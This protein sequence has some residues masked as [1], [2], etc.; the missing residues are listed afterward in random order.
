M[1]VQFSN[2]ISVVGGLTVLNQQVP[3]N[4]VIAKTFNGVTTWDNTNSYSLT[5]M[6]NGAAAPTI[7]SGNATTSSANVG[8]YTSFLT[9]SLNLS[10]IAYT[11]TD[12]NVSATISQ[13]P[14]LYTA[15]GS[16]YQY[17]TADPLSVNNGSL[18]GLFSP[19][20]RTNSTTGT[21]LFSTTANSTSNVGFYAI[22]GSGLT[23]TNTNYNSTIAQDSVNATR[24]HIISRSLN[25]TIS[26]TYDGTNSW[27]NANSY[28]LTGMVNGDAAPT[29]L[30]GT[31]TTSSANVGTYTSFLT[32]S[33]VLS[34]PNYT[35]GFGSNVSATIS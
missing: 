6:L 26:K 17:G 34:N 14:L 20:T 33:F 29:I 15:K 27:S 10:D 28:T 35:I 24:L 8:T 21:M 12:G 19:D 4:L 11:F 3:L 5:G 7:L 9:N 16:T 13:A 22:N 23:V 18:T 25:I 2:S 30:S 1:S 31:A 32:N